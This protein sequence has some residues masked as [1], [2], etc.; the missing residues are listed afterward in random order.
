MIEAAGKMLEG[1]RAEL[2]AARATATPEEIADM[3]NELRE[4]ESLFDT[5]RN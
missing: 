4:I 2:E 3:E 5:E 1:L